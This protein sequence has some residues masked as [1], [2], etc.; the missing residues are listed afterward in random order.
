M[1]KSLGQHFLINQSA[2]DRIVAAVSPQAGEVVIEIGPGAGAL[3]KPL[4]E[5]CAKVGARLIGIEKDEALVGPLARELAD[6]PNA[7]IV[8]A[9]VRTELPRLTSQLGAYQLVGN[10]P[11]YITGAL[12]RLIGELPQGPRL[13]T[14]MIQRE[15]AERVCSP[16]GQMSLLA[17][18]TQIWAEPRLMFVLP[19]SDFD[20]PPQVHS[21][22]IQLVTRSDIPDQKTLESYYRALHIIFKQPRKTLLNNLAEALPSRQEAS[23]FLQR[24]DL[25]ENSRPQDLTIAACLQLSKFLPPPY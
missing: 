6:W 3:T 13:T 10:I 5:Q 14:L 21:A 12:L 19:P 15:V 25:P 9:D 16:A 2:I 1:K 4:A 24:L 20:P 8:S 22:V 18:A 17:A 23:G 11:Y 7:E